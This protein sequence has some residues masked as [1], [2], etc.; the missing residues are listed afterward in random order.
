MRQRQGQRKEGGRASPQLG[1]QHRS[2]FRGKGLVSYGPDMSL[3]CSE[4][5]GGEMPGKQVDVP[6]WALQTGLDRN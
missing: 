1:R 2:R 4:P 3:R 6:V 5:A